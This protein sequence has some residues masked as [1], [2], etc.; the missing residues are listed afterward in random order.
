MNDVLLP[1]L[2]LLAGL[3]LGALVT[4]AVTRRAGGG[5]SAG[6]LRRELDQYRDDVANHYANTARK[7]DTLTRAYKDVYDHLEEGAHRLVGEEPLRARLQDAAPTTVTL[8]GIGARRLDATLPATSNGSETG[9]VEDAATDDAD[10]GPHAPNAKDAESLPDWEAS[11]VHAANVPD[12]WTTPAGELQATHDAVPPEPSAAPD[13]E[14]RQSA[15]QPGANTPVEHATAP[16]PSREEARE[17]DASEENVSE[18]DEVHPDEG[19]E[20]ASSEDGSSE[21]GSEDEA[22]EDETPRTTP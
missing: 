9:P 3:I 18:Q 19:H 10:R 7:I 1:A 20:D 15:V 11:D 8:E 22:R 16:A 2:T 12:A 13:D 21:D 4:L 5:R 6:D 17:D 14:A